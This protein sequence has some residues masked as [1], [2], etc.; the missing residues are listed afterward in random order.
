MK[1]I[2]ADEPISTYSLDGEEG[3]ACIPRRPMLPRRSLDLLDGRD[4]EITAVLISQDV[5]DFVMAKG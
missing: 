5:T 2:A 4:T 1:P 3:P